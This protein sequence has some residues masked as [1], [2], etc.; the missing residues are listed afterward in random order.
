[1]S[2]MKDLVSG[3]SI[4]IL[5]VVITLMARQMRSPVPGFGPE[6]FPSAIGILIAIFGLILAVQGFV[7]KGKAKKDGPDRRM[8]IVL[9]TLVLTAVYIIGLLWIPFLISTPVYL[10]ALILMGKST[11]EGALQNRFYPRFLAFSLIVSGM[12]YS[13][14]RFVFHVALI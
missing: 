6:V 9:V 3:V 1:M 7:G 8:K 10:M 4:S 11:K 14:F 2:R 12:I 5:G 13:V